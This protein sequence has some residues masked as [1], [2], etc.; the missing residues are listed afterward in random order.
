MAQE[1]AAAVGQTAAD[2]GARV[3]QTA[4][5]QA[6]EVVSETARQARDLLGEAGG[7]VRD[8]SSVQQ[9]KAASQLHSVADELH[10]MVAKG[11]Q[12]GLATEVAHQAAERL[13]GAASWLEQREPADVLQ[14]VRDFAR[15]RPAVF[16]AGAVAAGLA[17]GRLTRGMTDAARSGGEPDGQ[18]RSPRE[19]PS[20]AAIP[21][22]PAPNW[23]TPA[24]GYPANAAP[25]ATTGVVTPGATTAEPYYPAPARRP[26]PRRRRARQHSGDVPPRAAAV[27]PGEPDLRASAVASQTGRD[28]GN[29]S[30][31][32]LLGE[33]TR[34]LSTLMRQELA[35]AKAEVRQ[36]AV[37]AARAGGMLGAAGFAGYLVLLFAS[38]AIWQGLAEVM[39]SGW[40]ALIVT[41]LWAAV[42]AVLFVLGRQRMR[43]VNPKPERTVETVSEVPGTLKEGIRR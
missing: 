31:G 9:Q 27:T 42:G 43:E 37:K 41:V 5:D 33:V 35:L 15:R 14:A 25:A 26:R 20:G 16:L 11:G 21:P 18:R 36:E 17:A 8:Q 29:A 22:P 6:R 23:T 10:E 38:I 32:E 39:A 12:S 40:A 1:Q 3:T 19:I 24:P 4:T 13:H 30:V 7:Q 34:D 2:A 28:V